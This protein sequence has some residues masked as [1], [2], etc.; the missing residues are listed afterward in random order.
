MWR[1]ALRIDPDASQGSLRA[2][3]VPGLPMKR[4]ALPVIFLPLLLYAAPPSELAGALE[5]LRDQGSYSWEVINGDPGPV[6]QNFE[7]RRGTV[8]TVQQNM[9]PNVK[10]S[11]DLAGET[12]IVREW[13]DGMRLETLIAPD[14]TMVTHTPE[15]WLTNQEI[16]TLQAEERLRDGGP[17]DRFVW[18]RRADRPDVRR[19]DQELTPLL[20]TNAKFEMT[21][22]DT[23][24]LN[25]RFGEGDTQQPYDVTIAMHLRGGMIRDYE[26]ILEGGQP[27]S[28]A[29]VKVPV[30]DHRIVILT[31]V[32]IASVKVPAEAR[33]KLK[34]AKTGRR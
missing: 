12:L 10:G 20:K 27:V 31:Y 4:L 30:R 22:G 26:I 14:G 7:T 16:L 2:A 34:A 19:P 8:K 13:A 9:S 11:I 21:A 23:F 25:G 6:A 17:T 29:R 15:G 5:R 24:V 18:L 3:S 33:E 1:A 32:P 28:R